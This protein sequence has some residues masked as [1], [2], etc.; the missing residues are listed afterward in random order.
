[1]K[2]V[3]A[4]NAFKGSLTAS[5]AAIAMEAGIRKIL[6]NAEVVRVPVADG[7]DGLVEV[8]VEALNGEIHT[9]QVRG[10]RNSPVLANYCYVKAKDLVAVEMALAGGLSL[11]P[12]NLQDPTLTTT[13]GTVSYTHLTLP[14]NR[15]V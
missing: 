13:F 5:E 10:P 7:G 1:M 9:L 2:I 6:P 15:E 4:P 3:A 11:L 8:A 14:T 12:H